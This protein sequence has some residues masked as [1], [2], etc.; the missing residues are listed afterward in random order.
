MGFS[1]LPSLVSVRVRKEEQISEGG[2]KDKGIS[3]S[4]IN[5]E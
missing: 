3:K 2:E 4:D 1:F 5:T